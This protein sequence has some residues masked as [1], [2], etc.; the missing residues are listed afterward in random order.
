MIYNDLENQLQTLNL[1]TEDLKNKSNKLLEIETHLQNENYNIKI[2][3]IIQKKK[4][5]NIKIL[6]N[7]KM[8]KSDFNCRK[9]ENII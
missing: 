2:I 8:K 7:Y 4:K 3:V 1:E 5:K 9:K 6:Q